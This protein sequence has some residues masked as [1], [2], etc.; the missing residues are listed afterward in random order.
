M[1]KQ[2]IPTRIINEN[3]RKL[4][5][6]I[7]SIHSATTS[8]ELSK[9]VI[10]FHSSLRFCEDNK[11]DFYGRDLSILR[12][13]I[14]RYAKFKILKLYGLNQTEINEQDYSDLIKGRQ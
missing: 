5:G 2:E 14:E 13:T 4:L 9:N 3:K 12:S 10:A 11:I 7:S 8:F 6:S 1:L